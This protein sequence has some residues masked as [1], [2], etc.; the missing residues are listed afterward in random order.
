MFALRTYALS[1]EYTAMMF[2]TFEEFF[3]GRAMINVLAGDKTQMARESLT[4]PDLNSALLEPNFFIDPF[5]RIAYTDSWLD[6]FTNLSI[7]KTKPIIAITGTSDQTLNNVKKYG[8]YSGCMIYSYLEDKDRYILEG[9]KCIVVASVLVAKDKEEYDNYT[10]KIDSDPSANMHYTIFGYK[11][12]IIDKINE[13]K[14][15]GMTDLM[16][17]KHHFMEDENLI[18]EVIREYNE[19]Q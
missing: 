17:T 18:H 2:N 7:L 13:L 11:K 9:K 4:N 1:P 15:T 5:K 10:N 14:D 19:N 3:P 8:D 6:K 16:L 12:D